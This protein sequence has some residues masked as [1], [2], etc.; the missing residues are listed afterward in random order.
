MAV[1]SRVRV[2]S[3]PKGVR[4]IALVAARGPRYI[5]PLEANDRQWNDLWWNRRQPGFCRVYE[6]MVGHVAENMAAN[7][8]RIHG[9]R[10]PIPVARGMVRREVE[11]AMR[12]VAYGVGES[13]AVREALD[14]LRNRDPEEVVR[15]EAEVA[16]LPPRRRRSTTG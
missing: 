5:H 15:Q 14:A 10:L 4:S 3:L 8:R 1:V 9:R 13:F 11:R 16:M 2:R 12:R 6:L 7:A